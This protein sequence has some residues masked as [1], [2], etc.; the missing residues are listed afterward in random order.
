MHPQKSFLDLARAI[1]G[2]FKRNMS[3]D[4]GGLGGRGVGEFRRRPM[5]VVIKVKA[6]VDNNGS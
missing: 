1:E 4:T 5:S 6:H 3:R 2:E